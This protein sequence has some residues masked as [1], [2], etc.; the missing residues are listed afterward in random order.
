MKPQEIRS[1]VDVEYQNLLDLLGRTA[2][3]LEGL[4]IDPNLLK[5]YKK[6]LRYLRS[7]PSETIPEILRETAP[8]NAKVANRIQPDLSEEEIRSM[9][10]EK[11]LELASNEKTPR[12]HLEKIA[13]VKFGMTKGGLSALQNR[14]ALAEKIRT[15]I[16]NESTHDSITRAAGPQGTGRP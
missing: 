4:N 12:K 9:T 3:Y 13:A 5:S 8:T 15:L 11:I 7:R 2:K 14:A 16:R 10:T 6:L 1:G